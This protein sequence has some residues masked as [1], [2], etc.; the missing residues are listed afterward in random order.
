VTAIDLDLRMLAQARLIDAE[1][2]ATVEYLE[3]RARAEATGLE[4]SCMDVV[5]EGEQLTG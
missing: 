4:P 1:Q 5:D 3:A 2:G